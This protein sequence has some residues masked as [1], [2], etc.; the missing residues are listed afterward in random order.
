MANAADKIAKSELDLSSPAPTPK[1]LV[2]A[3][4]MIDVLWQAQRELC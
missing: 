2:E 1:T 3:Q 4:Q